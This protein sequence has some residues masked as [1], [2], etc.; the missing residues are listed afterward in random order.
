[1]EDLVEKEEV[2]T[3]ELPEEEKETIEEP[4]KEPEIEPEQDP[5]K[6]ELD[7]VQTKGRSEI[8]KAE[9]SLK[10][11]AER[12]KALGGDPNTIL[13][14]ENDTLIPDDEDDTPLTLGMLKKLQ[15]QDTA[16][17]ALQQADGIKN[18]TERELVKYHLQNTIR[19]TGNASEDLKLARSLVNA[20]KNT[21]IAEEIVR[22]PVAKTHSSGNGVPPKDLEVKG[23]LTETEKVFLGKP[24]NLTKEQIIKARQ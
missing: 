20:V 8:E 15:Q 24:F 19:S 11:N 22:K 17:S 1:M 4:E 2:L 5:L 9:F 23:T 13:G 18:E 10:K 7:R 3:P 21:K 6:T 14:I 16:K 12:V